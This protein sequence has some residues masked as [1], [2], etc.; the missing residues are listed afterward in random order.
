MVDIQK[1][2]KYLKYLPFTVKELRTHIVKSKCRCTYECAMSTN[3]LFNGDQ[4]FGLIK[5]IFKDILPK[6]TI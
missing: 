5:Q 4:Q 2:S 6:K 3:T 1:T